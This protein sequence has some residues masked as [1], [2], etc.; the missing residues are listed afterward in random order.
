MGPVALD[1]RLYVARAGT[2]SRQAPRVGTGQAETTAGGETR[3]L[4]RG[5]LNGFSA[6]VDGGVLRYSVTGFVHE[7]AQRTPPLEGVA[8]VERGKSLVTNGTAIQT[9][10]VSTERLERSIGEDR[11][12]A[13]LPPE[14]HRT[15]TALVIVD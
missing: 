13:R 4:A 8:A 6:R 15:Q 3:A 5:R 10:C 7:R 12:R 2:S 9:S 14:Q 11:E 1:R